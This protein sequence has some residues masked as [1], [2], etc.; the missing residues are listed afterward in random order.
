MARI[1]EAGR[2]MAGMAWPGSARLWLGVA[3]LAGRGKARPGPAWY[4]E[5]G[6]AGQAWPGEA[7]R[8]AARLGRARLGRLGPARRGTARHGWA[9]RGT[10]RQARRKR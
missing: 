9:R 1:G 8:G 10:A 3:R 2:G 4:R 5:A 6:Q 7:R